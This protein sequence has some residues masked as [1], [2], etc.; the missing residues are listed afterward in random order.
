MSVSSP[1]LVMAKPVGPVCNLAC[2]YCYYLDKRSLFPKRE[3]F[4][5][6][7]KVLS[8]FVKAHIEASPGPVVHFAFHG[9]EPTLAGLDFFKR[10]MEL[11]ELYL[12]KGWTAWN[13]LQTNGTR[14]DDSLCEFLKENSFSVGISL[15]GP[16]H[17]HDVHRR[18]RLDRPTYKK[19]LNG[20]NQ[21]RSH[22]IEPDVL[23]TLNST[24]VNYPEEVY[25]FF[26]DLGVSWL[27]F[28]PVVARD[29]AGNLL[30]HSVDP[31]LM[32]KFLITVFDEW[33]RYDL[34]RIG[35]QNFLECLLILDN[36]PPNLCIM[37]PECGNVLAMEHDGGLY[38]CD[39]FVKSENYLGNIT[40]DSLEE[41]LGSPQQ[42][43]FGNA[44]SA[45][46]VD[47]CRACPVLRVCNGGCPKDRFAT[48]RDGQAGINY[49][50]EGYLASYSHI[51][52]YIGE[53]VELLSESKPPSLLMSRLAE[54]ARDLRLLFRK[55]Q[56]NDPCPCGSGKKFKQ[57]C[58]TKRRG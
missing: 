15:D 56:R 55:A 52:P 54:R 21:L 57:C 26:L 13:N 50:C 44:K 14:L 31:R 10:V 38:S 42:R 7:D 36:K 3:P 47:Q 35:I 32:G 17:L 49:L 39:H 45:S 23:C 43:A 1:Y 37:S 5:M 20:L 58:I 24:N 28:L 22:G 51:L 2:D 40:T 29:Q 48:S 30:P 11:E 46:L 6:S 41:L 8:A 12:P 4:R 16:E 18:D 19:V 27:Q 34:K 9:G 25:H 53:M 33:V